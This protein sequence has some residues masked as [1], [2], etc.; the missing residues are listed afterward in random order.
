MNLNQI[1]IAP[2]L[3]LW[4]ILLLFFLGFTSAALQY[5]LIQRRLGHSRALRLSLLRLGAIFLLVA[6]TLNPFLVSKKEHKLSTAIAVLLDTSQS[7]GQP[8][9]PGKPTR[10]EQ[11]K[12]L[13]IEGTN[14]LLKSLNERFNVRLYGVGESLRA[15]EVK[16]L[17]DV[18]ARGMKGNLN[19]IL[20]E[21]SGKNALALLLSDGNLEWNEGPSTNLPLLTIPLG[22]PEAYKDI[23]I[24]SVKTP[25][26]AFKGREVIID[27]TIKSYGY[28]GLTLPVLLKEGGKLLSAKNVRINASPGE[29]TASLSFIPD[30][31]GQ[32]NLSL[33]IP[34]QFGESL[35]SN[36][37]LNLSLKVLRDKIRI[38]MVSG[39]PSMNYRFMRTA[40]KN[41]PSI[42]LL[43]FVILRTP[44]DTLNVPTNE[45]SLIPFPVETLFSKEIKNFDL[46][47]FDNFKYPLYLSLPHLESI[48]E[49]LR[50]GG[51]FAMI[52]G[53]DVVNEGRYGMTPIGEILPVRFTEKEVY[54]RDSPASIRLSRAGVVHSI[55]RLPSDVMG[56]IGGDDARRLNFWREMPTLDG[57]NLAEAKS[58]ATT[59]LESAD[60]ISWPI[61]VVSNYGNGRVLTLTT[62]YSWKWY[63]GMVAKGKGNLAYLRFVDRMVRWLT[64]DPDLNLVEI[65]LP[66]GQRSAGQ[67]IE[68]RIKLREEDLSPNPRSRA[69]FSVLDPD[70]VR[71]ETRL[72]PTGQ[73]GEYLGSF[74]PQKGGVY[75]LRIE[76][77]AGNLEESMVV[78]GLLDRL[79][80]APDHEQ[81][82]KIAASTGGRFLVGSADLL[83]EIEAYGKR[84]QRSFV[85]EKRLPLW[86]TTYTLAILLAL[87]GMEWYLRR[88]WGLI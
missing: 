83:R 10:L 15:I 87:L 74:L 40:L 42:D 6:F 30:E 63:V 56:E 31:V 19:E 76:T 58:S 85:E 65:T 12:K 81:L 86:A 47:I 25:S 66:E 24:K 69:S 70:G 23:L 8:E 55:T 88:K 77:S 5:R 80:A 27:V 59:L 68:A 44:S 53:P 51:G 16:E 52:G 62:D 1:S 2:V 84:G 17:G 38:L 39:S 22:N 75:K 26:L 28:T 60:G 82:K 48:R 18:E 54:R 78:A 71:I 29:G 14:P 37:N 72:K 20:K 79:D 50:G 11:A 57:I 61:L 73:K 64:K 43:S 7:M 67:E 3:P 21:I 32:K 46:L 33:S 9:G 45:Q 4:L 41:D 49:F 34:Q 13:L 36:N 35:A